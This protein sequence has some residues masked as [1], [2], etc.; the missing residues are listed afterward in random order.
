MR[1]CVCVLP[2]VTTDYRHTPQMASASRLFT[3]ATAENNGQWWPLPVPPC[4]PQPSSLSLL[5]ARVSVKWKRVSGTMAARQRARLP[6]TRMLNRGAR[7]PYHPGNNSTRGR[8]RERGCG[9]PGARCNRGWQG[10][11]WVALPGCRS[12]L[13]IYLYI[14]MEEINMVKG[15]KS[16]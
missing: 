14:L 8:G 3:A 2:P 6:P 11:A 15:Q 10:A 13:G 4:P 7:G 5:S 16:H 1:V 12:D 9:T